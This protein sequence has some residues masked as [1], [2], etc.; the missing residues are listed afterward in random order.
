MVRPVI[1][2]LAPREE[3]GAGYDFR[4]ELP[5]P[6]RPDLSVGAR[7]LPLFLLCKTYIDNYRSARSVPL[8][9]F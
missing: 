9:S 2:G 4:V 8:V 3:A 7:I 1:E 6:E 5:Y